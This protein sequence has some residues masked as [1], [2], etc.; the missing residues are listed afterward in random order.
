MAFVLVEHV[1]DDLL[2]REAHDVVALTGAAVEVD[3]HPV[4][5]LAGSARDH[6]TERRHT[7]LV[8][9][10]LIAEW[11]LPV[12]VDLELE[13]LA[14]VDEHAFGIDATAAR[15]DSAALHLFGHLVE[16]GDENL[17]LELLGT[18]LVREGQHPAELTLPGLVTGASGTTG[19]RA[20]QGR[21]DAVDAVRLDPQCLV[22]TDHHE[23]DDE[24]EGQAHDHRRALQGADAPDEQHRHRQGT[25]RQR[26]E[27][28]QSSATVLGGVPQIRRQVR[29]HQGRGVRG[30]DVEQQ[31]RDRGQSGDDGERRIAGEQVVEAAFGTEHDGFAELLVTAADDVQRRVSVDRNPHEDV[32]ER[33]RQGA[34]HE[35]ADGASAGDAGEEESDERSEGDPPGPEEQGPVGHPRSGVLEGEGL[36]DHVR[37][38]T[39][40]IGDIEDERVEQ[41]LR[42]SRHEHPEAQRD[43]E[44]DVEDGQEL[45]SLVHTRDRRERGDTDSDD[46]DADLGADADRNSE[47]GVEADVDH[48]DTDAQRGGHAEDRAQQGGEVDRLAQSTVD[49]FAEDRGQR[50]TD[51]QRHVHPVGEVG[52]SHTHE[53]VES[54]TAQAVVEERPDRRFAGGIDRFGFGA[55]RG[56]V[57]RD[58][59]GH[60]EEHEVGADAGGE[61]HRRP[62]DEAEFGLRVF[63]AELRVSVAGGRQVDDEDEDGEDEED[64]EPA[65][66]IGGPADDGTEDRL[67]IG[68]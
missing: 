24:G 52:Q 34:Q 14:V 33:N 40:E 67:G 57:H 11:V 49:A 5:V 16:G 38:Q 3:L 18:R 19:Q 51:R 48:D 27:D 28:A 15:G 32:D 53:C 54:P 46:D 47:D 35:L 43:G 50:R 21:I 4:V 25:G 6:S 62:G 63:G 59:F 1:I 23:D 45:D 66:P 13:E 31:S 10:H 42:V 30:G 60:G 44:D 36:A 2:L 64:V 65:E 37:E 8:R 20:G 22:Q 7:D 26:P 41:E 39:D 17:L 61:E 29:H 58:R 55:R 56:E 9:P 68:R 12:A